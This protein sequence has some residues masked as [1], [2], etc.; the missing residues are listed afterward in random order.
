MAYTTQHV[1]TWMLSGVRPPE[2]PIFVESLVVRSGLISSQ[3]CPPFVVRI[4]YWL[5]T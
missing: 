4:T 3:L 2:I 1:S 5:P